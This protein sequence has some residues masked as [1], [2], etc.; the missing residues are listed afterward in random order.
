MGIVRYV[1]LY[2]LSV[3]YSYLIAAWA[4][5][6]IIKPPQTCWETTIPYFFQE[7]WCGSTLFYTVGFKVGVESWETERRESS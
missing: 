5:S 3:I 2:S 7:S 1:V 6:I 4:K